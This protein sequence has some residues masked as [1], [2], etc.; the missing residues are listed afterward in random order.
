MS[1]SQISQ[2]AVDAV[3]VRFLRGDGEPAAPQPLSEDARVR[4][5]ALG[6]AMHDIV[7]GAFGSDREEFAA[8]FEHGR[9][10][11]SAMDTNE[12]ID[13]LHIPD[14]A[15]EHREALARLL[16]RIP[17]GWGRWISCSSGWFPL[18]TRAEHELARQCPTFA[19]E[20]IKEKYGTLRLYVEFDR[21]DDIPPSLRAVEPRCPS[22]A[23][24]AE[25][26]GLAD[27]EHNEPLADAWRAA[28]ESIF[29]PAYVTWSEKV[30][31]FRA[32]DAGVRAAE[33]QTRRAATFEQLV[34]QFEAESATTCE[35]CGRRGSL[36]RSQAKVPWYAVRCDACRDP[37]WTRVADDE[38]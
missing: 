4:L 26:L 30:D 1:G 6:D 5:N 13:A 21:D 35:I 22:R 10:I 27:V 15:G 3:F 34:K 7:A 19:V 32:S 9:Q 11:G 16:V 29:T 14:D 31:G 20:Q 33:D 17:D 24:V 8:A 18:L 23:E 25:H 28:H 38:S 12:V 2:N 37:E 36:S